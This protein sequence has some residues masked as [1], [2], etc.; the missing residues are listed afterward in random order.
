MKVVKE[1]E[2][3]LPFAKGYERLG[4]VD[5]EKDAIGI[6]AAGEKY[7]AGTL[8]NTKSPK[9]EYTYEKI[10]KFNVFPGKPIYGE[11]ECLSVEEIT[12][13]FAGFLTEEQVKIIHDGK[14][15]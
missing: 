4:Y 1:H 13:K 11:F 6:V 10:D 7:P 2:D 5:N 8:S 14:K 3:L 9:T 15:S 12:K